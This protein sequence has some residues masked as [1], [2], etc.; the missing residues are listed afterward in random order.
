MTDLKE[1]TEKLAEMAKTQD[2]VA[3]AYQG[4]DEK[5]RA[6]WHFGEAYGLRREIALV[7]DARA[8]VTE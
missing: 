8:E 2:A 5:E 3:T 1:I 6:N 4:G 7:C